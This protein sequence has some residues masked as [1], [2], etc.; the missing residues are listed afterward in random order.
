ML[1]KKQNINN[2]VTTTIAS[3]SPG[4]GPEVTLY[5]IFSHMVKKTWEIKHMC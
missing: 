5:C 4:T 1:K 3:L 2:N